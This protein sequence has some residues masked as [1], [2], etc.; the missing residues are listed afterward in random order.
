MKNKS[1]PKNKFSISY[2]TILMILLIIGLVIIFGL[3]YFFQN[4]QFSK[5]ESSPSITVLEISL[6]DTGNDMLVDEMIPLTDLEAEELPAYQFSVKNNGKKTGTYRIYLEEVPVGVVNDGCTSDTLLS[7]SQL[8]YSLISDD[9][10]EKIQDMSDI[11]MNVLD[12][13]EIEPGEEDLYELRVWIRQ[14][15][16]NT[17]W[18]NKHYHYQIRIEAINEEESK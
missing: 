9:G 12:V 17:E 1:Q 4:R 14:D 3:F 11:K 6:S 2:P 10:E 16:S 18:Q 15:Q 7:R 13:K 8:R 5:E